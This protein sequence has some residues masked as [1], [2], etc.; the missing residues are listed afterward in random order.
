MN[1]PPSS[2]SWT[3]LKEVALWKL[4]GA[5]RVRYLNGQVTQ[6]IVSL[7]PG[8]TRWAA[9]CNAKGRMDGV[10]QVTATADALYIQGPGELRESL[11]ARLEKYLIA[12]D[13]QLEDITES[14]NV[15]HW[16]GSTAPALSPH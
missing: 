12:D 7:R 10:L 14:W 16:L 4:T 9:V 3:P 11:G 5:D 13:A 2:F 6:D 8:Q 15:S 1:N